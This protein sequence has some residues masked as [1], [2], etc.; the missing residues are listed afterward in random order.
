VVSSAKLLVLDTLGVGICSTTLPWSE[1][2]HATQ[3]LRADGG[4]DQCHHG[5]RVRTRRHGPRR[6]QRFGGLKFGA[7]DGA[8]WRQDMFEA[9]YGR[10]CS[11][12]TGN[13][14][15]AVYDLTQINK[16]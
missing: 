14:R 1:R 3:I 10:F 16:D 7:G 15:P 13:Q 6:S 5:V 12:H 11:A 2:L 4:H 9:E 8:A